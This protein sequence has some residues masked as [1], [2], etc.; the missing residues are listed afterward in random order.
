ML[1]LSEPKKMLQRGHCVLL[2]A[3]FALGVL[4]ASVVQAQPISGKTIRIVVPYAPGAVQ[5][6]IARSVNAELGAALKANVIVENRPG[7]GG[8]IG[9]AQ[10]A[11][12][13]ADGTTLVLAAA[14]HTIAGS[15]YAKLAYDPVRD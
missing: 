5:D 9:T 4:L 13:A 14:S 6:T 2:S 3:L 11:R 1:N 10:V 12:S 7:A 8:T 15:L